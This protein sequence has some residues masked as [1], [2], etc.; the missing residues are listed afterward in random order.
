M[1]VCMYLCMCVSVCVYCALPLGISFWFCYIDFRVIM[2]VQ[3]FQ[4][5]PKAM[6][7]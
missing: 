7:N 6:K 2:G 4:L 3:T 1:H 5:E